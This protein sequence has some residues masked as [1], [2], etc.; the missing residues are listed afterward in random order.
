MVVPNKFRKTG[1]PIIATYNFQD[2]ADGS[3]IVAFNLGVESDN[4]SLSYVLDANPFFSDKVEIAS[5]IST[6][7]FDFTSKPFG[8]QRVASGV[9]HINIGERDVGAGN[10]T[11]LTVTLIRLRGV[12]ETAFSS[13]IRTHDPD[14]NSH[15]MAYTEIP[16]TDITFIKGDKLICR[17]DWIVAGSTAA[18]G[19]D[20]MGRAGVFLTAALINPT[21]TTKSVLFMPFNIE[22]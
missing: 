10:W 22:L 19:T 4:T 20:P 13:A 17:I 1:E 21:M 8:S 12:V 16:L 14:S 9:A 15:R 6:H 11:S 3:G 18:F 5:G 7:Q 2:V